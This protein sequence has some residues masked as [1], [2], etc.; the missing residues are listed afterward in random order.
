MQLLLVEQTTYCLHGRLPRPGGFLLNIE[1]RM[2]RF[3][4]LT[5]ESHRGEV[6][7]LK[8]YHIPGR[9]VQKK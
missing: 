9:Y 3:A 8:K 5:L 7:T 2:L 4:A 6:L 1:H